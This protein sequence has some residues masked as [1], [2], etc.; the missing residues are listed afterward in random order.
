MSILSGVKVVEVALYGFVPSAAAVL[1][2]QGAEVVKVVH[3]VLGDP[4]MGIASWGI[5]PGT[6]GVMYLWESFNRG[7]QSIGI[8]LANPKGRELLS[9]FVREADVFVTNFLPDARRRLRIDVEDIQGENPR[10]IYARGSAHGPRGPEADKGG[11]DGVTYWQR[12][13]IGSALGLEAGDRPVGMPGPGFGDVQ[14]GMSLAGGILGALY[15]RERTGEALVVDTSLL[16]QGLWAMQASVAGAS[17]TGADQLARPDPER[18]RNPLNHQYVTSDGRFI[19][20][21]MLESDRYWADFCGRIGRPELA[22]DPRFIDLEARATNTFECTQEISAAFKQRP[23]AEWVTVLSEEPGQWSTVATVGEAAVD[24]QAVENGYIETF[25]FGGANPLR[26][27]R[28]PIQYN[29]TTVPQVRAPESA[30]NT[31]ELLLKLGLTWDDIIDLK[32]E[33]VIT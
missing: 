29:E 6:G 19:A 8:D 13:G 9:R 18:P 30:G 14:A 32:T 24:A 26:L 16:A 20:L 21:A 22:S 1:A 25:D 2:D 12:S 10:I 15:H 28:S 27:V 31:E 23:L 33:Q 3:P 11:F 17:V 5:P 4:V 7:K